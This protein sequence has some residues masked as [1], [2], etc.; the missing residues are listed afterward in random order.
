MMSAILEELEH[1]E[2]SINKTVSKKIQH[3]FQVS[4]FSIK[5]RIQFLK[6]T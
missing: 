3:G 2:R 1:T 6:L 5:K 4:R